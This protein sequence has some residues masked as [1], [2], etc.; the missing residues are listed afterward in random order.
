MTEEIRIGIIGAGGIVKHRH[1]PGFQKI[2]GVRVTT[3]CNRTMESTD[4]VAAEFGI[5]HRLADWRE[6][7]HHP[8][9]DAVLVG[10]WPYMHRE[11]SIEAM[12]AG[13]PVFC[14]ARMARNLKEAREM[15]A[16]Q[17]E[18][19]QV[20]MLCPP[21]HGMKWDRVI[22]RLLAEKTIGKVLTIRVNILGGDY[23]DHDAPIHWRQIREYS[24][25]NILTLGIMAEV[26]HRWFGPHRFAHAVAQTH[27]T[28]R[29]DPKTGKEREVDIPDAVWIHGET[30]SGAVIQYSLSG[31]AHAAPNHSVEVY[32]CHGTIVYDLIAERVLTAQL[33]ESGLKEL[34]LSDDECR[35][36]EVEQDFIRAVRGEKAPEPSFEDGVA[37]MEWVEA[38]T[39]SYQ[40]GQR[41]EL[42]LGGE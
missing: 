38:V 18:T 10:T 14:Q 27:V 11:C 41:I 12:R 19:G 2:D 1:L 8:E 3:V 32:G 34:A 5:P 6:V 42:P 39:Q 37:Y 17:K 31:L 13:K 25:N 24:G 7:V 9:V 28:A 40:T 30:A 15:R 21:P 23:L 20:A 22:R 35:G 33:G 26:I 29:M 16:V 36:W 4:K